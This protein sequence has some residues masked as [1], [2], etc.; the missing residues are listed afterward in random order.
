[1]A[2]V[3]ATPESTV[4]SPEDVCPRAGGLS[5]RHS[6]IWKAAESNI[7]RCI[8]CGQ[9]RRR[10]RSEDTVISAAITEGDVP[11]MPDSEIFR[12]PETPAEE[13]TPL[14]FKQQGIDQ[15]LVYAKM[16]A[17]V[18]INTPPAPDGGLHSSIPA[19]TGTGSG[20]SA[21][22]GTPAPAVDSSPTAESAPAPTGD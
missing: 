10:T 14:E 13:L 16:N 9:E 4:Q 6:F 8:N 3:G 7:V 5:G 11:E 17:S 2:E 18:E 15:A 1:M 20:T 12:N 22:M 19:F 21:E